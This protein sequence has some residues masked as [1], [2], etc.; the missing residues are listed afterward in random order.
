MLWVASR[1]VQ[2]Y[3]T[4]NLAIAVLDLMLKFQYSQHSVGSHVA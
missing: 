3:K 4:S 1:D 2:K